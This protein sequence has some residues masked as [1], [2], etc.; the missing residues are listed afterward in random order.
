MKNI[1]DM[2][3]MKNMTNMTNMKSM[4]QSVSL[5][6][7]AASTLFIGVIAVADIFVNQQPV[8]GGTMRES[9]LWKDPGPDGNDS[10]LD[11]ICWTDFTLNSP[12]TIDH[13]EWWGTGLTEV[14]FRVEIWKQ[15]PNTIA[16]QP[17]GFFYY[18]GANPPPVPTVMFETNAIATSVGPGGL[19]HY[20]LEVSTPFTLPANTPENV[21][22]FIG[23]VGLS[24]QYSASWKWAR[25]SGGS[26]ATAR[27]M[28]GSGG[29][30]FQILGEGRAL[31][32]GD[33]SLPCAGDLDGDNVVGAAD[34][35]IVLGQWG[36]A[37]T[38]DM[39]GDGIV[40]AADLGLLL[41]AWG[42]CP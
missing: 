13:I 3:N 37:G 14:G 18:G 35:A 39:S 32:I 24:Q 4:T 5:A 30:V 33:T 38:A 1:K 11:T 28:H 16:Y 36:T 10:D 27:W 31:V 40:D 41:G 26:N 12:T 19:T 7:V 42:A 20:T 8:V 34:L 29:P 21:R 6:L 25:G 22:W 2:K 15:D 17:L 9:H 23:V